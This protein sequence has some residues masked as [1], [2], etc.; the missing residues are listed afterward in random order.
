M[1][2]LVMQEDAR[3]IPECKCHTVTVTIFLA[4]SGEFGKRH[5][6]IDTHTHTQTHIHTH[7]PPLT[8][9]TERVLSESV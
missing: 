8:N 2:A 7:T 1:E 9:S 3:R 5:T 6:E 4:I